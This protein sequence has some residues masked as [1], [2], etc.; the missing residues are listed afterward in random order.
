MDAEVQVRRRRRNITDLCLLALLD[1]RPLEARENVL[2]VLCMSRYRVPNIFPDT[3]PDA[4]L[5]L[6]HSAPRGGLVWQVASGRA[7]GTHLESRKRLNRIRTKALQEHL[8]GINDSF[9]LL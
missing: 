5:L 9:R 1:V 6:L 4:V 3:L 7:R 2:C 8:V